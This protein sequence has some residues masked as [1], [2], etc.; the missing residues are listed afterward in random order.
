MWAVKS[1]LNLVFRRQTN[2]QELAF[3]QDP[4]QNKNCKYIILISGCKYTLFLHTFHVMTENKVFIG[5]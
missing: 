5:A 4:G 3:K 2:F 1:F